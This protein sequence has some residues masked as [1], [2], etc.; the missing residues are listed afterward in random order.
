MS[1]IINPKYT[2]SIPSLSKEEYEALK[3][4]ISKRGLSYLNLLSRRKYL[5]M[6]KTTVEESLK[7]IGYDFDRDV[8]V[9]HELEI[10]NDNDHMAAPPRGMVGLD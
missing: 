7:V 4:D 8:L 10:G 5:E 2:E 6:L 3:D 9:Q 1:L